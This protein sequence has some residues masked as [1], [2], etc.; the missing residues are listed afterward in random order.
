MSSNSISLSWNE[1]SG[2]T[3]YTLKRNGL[4]KDLRF[5]YQASR[6]ASSTYTLEVITAEDTLLKVSRETLYTTPAS[7]DASSQTCVGAVRYIEQSSYGANEVKTWLI[8]PQEVFKA[9]KLNVSTPCISLDYNLMAWMI[10]L[11]V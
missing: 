9:I 8:S 4:S 6:L 10:V 11:K 2:A 5:F 3:K 7:G 1:F